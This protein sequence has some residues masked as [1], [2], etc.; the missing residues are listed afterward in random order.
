MEAESF[1]VNDIT[2][3][4][5]TFAFYVNFYH[6]CIFER[7]KVDRV[8][9]SDIAVFAASRPSHVTFCHI[10]CEALSLLF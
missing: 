7:K 9:V 1:W 4:A 6:I 8:W 2:V 5:I 3:L 10:F